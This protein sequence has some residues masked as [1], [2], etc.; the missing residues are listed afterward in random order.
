MTKDQI[1]GF[2]RTGSAALIGYLTAK[3][4]DAGVVTQVVGALGVLV[5]AGWS[6]WTNRPAKIA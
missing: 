4:Y 2:V 3:G 6:A 5:V 1:G